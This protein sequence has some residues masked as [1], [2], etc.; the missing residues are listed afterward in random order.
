MRLLRI[1]ILVLALAGTVHAAVP[2]TTGRIVLS[3]E[4]SGWKA[5]SIYSEINSAWLHQFYGPWKSALFKRVGK[6]GERFDCNRYAALF[7]AEVQVSFFVETFHLAGAGQAAAI[8]EVWYWRNGDRT[9][10]HALVMAVTERG[11]VYFEPQN[12][13]EVTL[14]TAEKNSIYFQ[15]F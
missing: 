1:V 5:D 11:R 8:G 15:R 10:A 4:I 12:G 6:G 9:T 7:C 2:M 3:D 13:K 14:S